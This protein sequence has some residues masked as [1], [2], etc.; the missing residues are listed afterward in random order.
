MGVDVVHLLGLKPAVLKRLQ[1]SPAQPVALG[2]GARDVV[3]VAGCPIA[4]TSE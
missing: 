2:V 3:G 4:Y 1:K